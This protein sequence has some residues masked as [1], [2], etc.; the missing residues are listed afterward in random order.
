MVKGPSSDRQFSLQYI[1][2]D[3]V[4]NAGIPPVYPRNGR[5]VPKGG[6]GKDCRHSG[7]KTYGVIS[8]LASGILRREYLFTVDKK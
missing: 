8:V 6:G 3:L 1:L 7:S 4:Q 2:P 5:H